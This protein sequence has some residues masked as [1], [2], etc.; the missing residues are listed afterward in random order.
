MTPIIIH[1]IFFQ[2]PGPRKPF[3]MSTESERVE[4]VPEQEPPSSVVPE[5]KAQC[6]RLRQAV[7]ELE[8]EK[9]RDAEA[10]AAAQAELHGLRQLVYDWA[11]K[12]VRDEDW[13]DFVAEDY[14]ISADDVLAELE[15]T[16]ES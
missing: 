8:Q 14:T 12:Q 4:G 15:R 13:D 7:Q 3:P 16:E 5:I 9:K 1:S 6:E 2:I 10:L 11:H